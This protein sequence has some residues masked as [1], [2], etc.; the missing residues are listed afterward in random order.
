M[1]QPLPHQAM[2]GR[3]VIHQQRVHT[4]LADHQHALRLPVIA[5]F[6]R[7]PLILIEFADLAIVQVETSQAPKVTGAEPR[8][9]LKKQRVQLQVLAGEYR[10]FMHDTPPCRSV[11]EK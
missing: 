10:R 1:G 6:Q 8:L 7:L 11:F 9:V 4:G 5:D 3:V 2:P